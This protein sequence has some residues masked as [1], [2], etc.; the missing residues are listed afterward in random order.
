[1]IRRV[2][3]GYEIIN[4]W[5]KE[6]MQKVVDETAMEWWGDSGPFPPT[7]QFVRFQNN[8]NDS[9]QSATSSQAKMLD[10]QIRKSIIEDN[11]NGK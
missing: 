10:D 6:A 7:G 3:K 4:R 2:R 1:M 9:A 11:V 5:W 8:W